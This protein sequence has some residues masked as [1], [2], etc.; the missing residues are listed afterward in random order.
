[1]KLNLGCG[2]K[3]LEGFVNV[4]K[5][6]T[7][8]TDLVLDLETTPWPWPSDCAEEVRFIHSLEHM[9]H[10]TEVCL[11]IMRELYRVCADGAKI[12]IHAPHPRCDDYLGDPTHVR[13]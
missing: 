1:M 11:G 12:V 4:D 2:S 9:G 6:R 13:P 3:A 8:A 5:Y 7:D 10:D